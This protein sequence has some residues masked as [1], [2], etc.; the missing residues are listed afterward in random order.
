MAIDV[1]WVT[2]VI[3]VPKSYMTLVQSIPTEIRSLDID[4]FRHDLKDLEASVVGA[5]YMD[6]HRHSPEVT[7]GGVT[8]ARVVEII[9][10]YTVTFEDDQYAVNLMGANSNIADVTNVNQVSVRSSNSAGLVS[11]N[12]ILRNT[13]VL[14][15]LV[16]NPGRGHGV[17]GH[18]FYWDPINGNNT[19]DGTTPESAVLTWAYLQTLLSTDGDVV[20]VINSTGGDIVITEQIDIAVNRVSIRG[21]GRS[22]MF[23]PT[24]A[25]TVPTI[26]ITGNSVGLNGFIVETS[27]TTNTQSCISITGKSSVIS[28]CWIYRGG[29]YGAEYLSGDYHILAKCHVEKNVLD[30]VFVK[31][32]GLSNGSPREVDIDRCAIYLNTRDGVRYEAIP[33]TPHASTRLNSI[34]DSVIRNNGEI[35]VNI[36]D[37]V[38]KTLIR[39]NVAIHKNGTGD[40]VDNG[41]ET[42]LGDSVQAEV[43]A[44]EVRPSILPLYSLL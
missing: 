4:L 34:T 36:G 1:D 16:T 23:K 43:T 12:E 42:T 41:D 37:N 26:T 22:I 3:Y 11:Q 25:Q 32:M 18:A 9:N 10:G 8:L 7:V 33:G 35:G 21:P 5:I 30:G 40:L 19:N 17:F 27:S 29:T 38:W 24:G 31:D 13:D 2:K 39:G 15:R 6:T 44:G 20:F 14:K 28:E